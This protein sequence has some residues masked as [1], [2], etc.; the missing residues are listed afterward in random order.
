MKITKVIN[1]SRGIGHIYKTFRT[2]KLCKTPYPTLNQFVHAL[3]GFDTRE[4]KEKVPQ[5][6]H[7]ITFSAQRGRGR[8]NYSQRRGNN[9]FNQEKEASRLL[10]K[11][12]VLVTPETDQVLKT[13]LQVKVMKETIMMC[14]KF[15]VGIIIILLSVFTGET[16]FTKPTDELPQA[17]TTTNL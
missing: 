2:V 7:N 15:V 6:N 3:R 17:L 14:V 9:N 13:V 11:E 10:D 1:F 5:Q 16:T 4:D 8:G 12:H